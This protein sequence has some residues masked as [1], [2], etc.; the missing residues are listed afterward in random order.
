[1][2]MCARCGHPRVV[3]DSQATYQ[4]FNCKYRGKVSEARVLHRTYSLREAVHLVQKVKEM[5]A[6]GE[7]RVVYDTSR[8]RGRRKFRGWFTRRHPEATRL[9]DFIDTDRYEVVA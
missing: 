4:C 6:K 3:R 2:I 5:I 1:V 8:V 7:I 9:E